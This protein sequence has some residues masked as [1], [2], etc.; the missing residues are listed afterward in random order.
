MDI[1]VKTDGLGIAV[2]N[3]LEMRP[4]AGRALDRL[5]SG[6]EPM[7][8]WVQTPINQNKEE[9]EYILN[10]AD[11]VKDEAELFVVVGIGGSYL[12]A[13]AAIE[14]L[15]KAER[16]AQVR[17]FGTNF[18]T[19]Y[20]RE[21]MAEIRDKRTILCVISKSGNTAE[22]SAAFE[23][24]KPL[25]IEKYGSEEEANKRIIV[26]TDP[27]R[28][29][30]RAEAEEKGYAT[31]DIPPNI[32]GRYSV[33][34]PVGLL[35]M[36]VSGI[37]IRDVLDGAKAM[38]MSP[39]WDEGGT[40]YAI[41]RHLMQMTGKHIEVIEMCHSRLGYLGEWMKQLYGE[42]EG[43]NGQGLWPATL[44][45]STDLHSMGQMIQ[46]GRQNFFETMITVDDP[47]YTV[48]VPAGHL[49]GRTIRELNEAMMDGVIRAHRNAG[50]PVVEI[51]MP[52]LTPHYYGQM[53]Y[54]LETTCAVT[55][56]LNGVDPFNQPGVEAYKAEMRKI[57]GI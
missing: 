8:G 15:P 56:M 53:L 23:T 31:F 42:S 32:G 54:F 5:W 55:A 28:G 9:L 10:A 20:Y 44:T 1:K 22:V 38:A 41:S 46:E 12:G 43:K 45:L 52:Q 49:A 27:A 36:A 51:H 14:A 34:T 6:S 4:E 48:T 24:L 33:L 50:I 26:V 2:E 40:D 13:K 47:D 57:L 16:G 35:P 7:T 18:C 3:I 30:L 19:D 37:D 29:Q 39:V 11:I 21:V 25:M 17:F